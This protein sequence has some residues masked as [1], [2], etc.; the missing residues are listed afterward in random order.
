MHGTGWP[1]EDSS[2]VTTHQATGQTTNDTVHQP[3]G[4]SGHKTHNRARDM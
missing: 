2:D 4:P 3:A 1:Q